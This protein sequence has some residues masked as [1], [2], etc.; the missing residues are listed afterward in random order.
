VK[1]R[2]STGDKER[3]TP[4][5]HGG[6]NVVTLLPCESHPDTGGSTLDLNNYKTKLYEIRPK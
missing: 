4:R 6:C 3:K 1:V 2:G 5:I